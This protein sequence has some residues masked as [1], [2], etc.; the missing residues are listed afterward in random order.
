MFTC[1]TF[2][3]M[4]HG[5]NTARIFVKTSA[6]SSTHISIMTEKFQCWTRQ[7]RKLCFSLMRHCLHEAKTN[8]KNNILWCSKKP[9]CSWCHTVQPWSWSLMCSYH[10]QNH[11]A[12]V[13]WSTI[14]YIH[15]ITLT[16]FFREL[17]VVKCKVTSCRI[18]SQPT[19][20]ISQ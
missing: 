2:E 14:N 16:P 10:A 1:N 4:C 6:N 20:Q 19:Q 15:C 7:Y 18:T 13:F 12:R 5:K 8:R 17:T 11:R 9:I 3:S